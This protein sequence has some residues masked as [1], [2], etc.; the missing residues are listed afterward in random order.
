MA[1]ESSAEGQIEPVQDEPMKATSAIPVSQTYRNSSKRP[2]EIQL[3]LIARLWCVGSRP[4]TWSG[5]EGR[6][7]ALNAASVEA[8]TTVEEDI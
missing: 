1:A 5:Q 4:P 2:T 6:S 7:I 3:Y 8:A